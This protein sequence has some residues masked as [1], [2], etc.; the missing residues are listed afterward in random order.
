MRRIL[1]RITGFRYHEDALVVAGVRG[2]AYGW[3]R[4]FCKATA[5]AGFDLRTC[6]AK[7]RCSP[8]K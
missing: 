2:S 1:R 4:P 8:L 7:S 6:C 5:K 3:A